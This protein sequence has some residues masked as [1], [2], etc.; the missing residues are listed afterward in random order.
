MVEMAREEG[1]RKGG[2][3]YSACLRCTQSCY[4][5]HG[6]GKPN[7]DAVSSFFKVMLNGFSEKLVH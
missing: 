4:R 6:D 3:R 5:T 2:T 1:E 7:S